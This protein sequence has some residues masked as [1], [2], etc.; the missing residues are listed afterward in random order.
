MTITVGQDTSGT[1]KT[2]SA[3]GAS[4]AY[5]SIPAA[6]AAALG[7][8]S[9]VHAPMKVVQENMVCFEGGGSTV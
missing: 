9:Q 1:R 4:V 3:G 5:Y 2:L 8:F 6:Q 7:E